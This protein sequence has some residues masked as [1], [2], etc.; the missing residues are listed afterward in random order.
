MKFSWRVDRWV[1]N[2]LYLAWGGEEQDV[3][4]LTHLLLNL[5]PV[6]LMGDHEQ[7]LQPLVVR[8]AKKMV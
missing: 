2:L 8:A 4:V 1:H 3:G 5:L 6:L 7:R